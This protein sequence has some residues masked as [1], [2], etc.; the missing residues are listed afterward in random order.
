M[1][2]FKAGFLR[3]TPYGHDIS[4]TVSP[5][6]FNAA[7]CGQV[8]D[9][10]NLLRLSAGRYREGIGIGDEV[11][12]LPAGGGV[13]IPDGLVILNQWSGFGLDRL[14]VLPQSNRESVVNG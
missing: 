3:N 2:I 14:T 4:K 13:G 7:I 12:R 5:Q 1:I 10:L 8:D 6:I 9:N 11:A